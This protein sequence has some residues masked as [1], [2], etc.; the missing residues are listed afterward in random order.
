MKLYII[1]DIHMVAPGTLSKGLDPAQRLQ[2]A[3]DDLAGHHADSD[4]C[5]LLGDLADHG[6]AAAYAE[7]RR[8]LAGVTTPVVTMLGNHD[9]R[10]TF[11]TVFHDAE[12][13]ADGFVQTVRDTPAGRLIFLDTFEPGYASGHFCA[14]RQA[15]LAVRLDEAR[16]RPVH[17]FL[18]HPPFDIGTVV[19]GIKLKDADALGRLL[20]AHG[21][22]RHMTAGHTHRVCS[23]VWRGIAFGNLGSTS[24]NV[25]VHLK[26]AAGPG[27]RFADSIATG[28]MLISD[29]QVVLHAHDVNPGREPMAPAL[30]P[31]ARVAEILARGGKLT[32]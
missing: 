30:F 12:L 29:D 22:V 4:L 32:P 9:D 11:R 25:G 7:L 1:S 6:D 23:G 14:K 3:L 20:A 26:G 31:H 21:R 27:D 17:L 18:H 24:Y 10:A 16:D 15:W 28:V 19:D 8:M 2:C 13:D 5:V